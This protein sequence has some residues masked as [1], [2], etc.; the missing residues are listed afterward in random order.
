MAEKDFSPFFFGAD[1]RLQLFCSYVKRG[2]QGPEVK[3]PFDL[4]WWTEFNF[5]QVPV[6][7]EA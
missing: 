3:R 4:S 1:A 5:G 6:C 7:L 2:R